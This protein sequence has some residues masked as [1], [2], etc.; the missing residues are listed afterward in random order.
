MV[1]SRTLDI[2][3]T[4]IAEAG[5]FQKLRIS[6]SVAKGQ[7]HRNKAAKSIFEREEHE[8]DDAEHARQG[9]YYLG[10]GTPPVISN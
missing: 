6:A 10:K 3:H 5:L 8:H 9:A 7:S 4:A 1:M 2:E